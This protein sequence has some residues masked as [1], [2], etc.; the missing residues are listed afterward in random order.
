MGDVGSK[1]SRPDPLPIRAQCPCRG[2]DMLRTRSECPNCPYSQPRISL[3]S[4]PQDLRR[5]ISLSSKRASRA[6]SE[7]EA[8]RIGLIW[9]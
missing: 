4:A 9:E 5:K 3:S 6:P 8:N 2:W 1:S 7:E